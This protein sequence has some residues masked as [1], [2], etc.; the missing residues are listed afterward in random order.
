[1]NRIAV[2][3]GSF[4]PVTLGHVNIVERA[5]PLF[6]KIIIAVGVN[7]QKQTHFPPEQRIYWLNEIFEEQSKVEVKSFEGLT[8]EFCIA[9]QANY[10]LRGV[11]NST[12]FDYER[13]IASLNKSM[14]D[15]IETVILVSRPDLSHISSTIVKELIRYNGKFGHLVPA[16]VSRDAIKEVK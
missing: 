3:P 11:R 7:S 16:C 10:I 5:M 15:F 8:V 14:Y 13:T 9:E 6:D 4:D 1:M 12:D 2:F